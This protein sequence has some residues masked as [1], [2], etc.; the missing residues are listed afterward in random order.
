LGETHELQQAQ[1]SQ[2]TKPEGPQL[3]QK[4]TPSK[5]KAWRFKFSPPVLASGAKRM[6]TGGNAMKQKPSTCLNVSLLLT[7]MTCPVGEASE[8]PDI[9]ITIHVYNYAAVSEKTLARAKEE[10]G[11]IFGNAGLTALWVDHALSAVDLRHPHHSTDSW[12]GT[13]YV[14]RLLTRSPETS[15]K[16]AMGEALSLDIAN[17]FMNRVTEQAT[18]GELSA[19]R[20]LGHALAH[21]IGHLL[22]GDNSHSL[23]GGIMV[24]PWSKEDLQRMVKGGLLFT[25]QEVTRIQAELR[26][27]SRSVRRVAD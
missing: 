7:A 8:A 25:H 26:H 10:A 1:V 23:G 14:L 2:P 15:S 16:N 19:S 22:L 4:D 17:V 13:D 21:E 11:R 27:R 20:M 5:K 12:D 6:K 9:T 18:D 3:N 24:A